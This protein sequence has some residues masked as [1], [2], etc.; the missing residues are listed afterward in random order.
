QLEE[1]AAVAE[2]EGLRGFVTVQ[3]EYSVLHRVPE[4]E[5]VL[6]ACERLGLRFIPYFPLASGA[7]TGKYRRGKPAPG[8]TRLGCQGDKPADE[9]LPEDR[10]DKVERL[11]EF[12]ESRGHAL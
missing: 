1:A 4:R 8:R 9:V 6:D 7:L 3:N 11:A 10:L 12:A 5:G 2:K